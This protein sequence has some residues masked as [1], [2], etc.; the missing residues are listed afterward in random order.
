MDAEEQRRLRMELIEKVVTFAE[1]ILPSIQNN[2]QIV[3]WDAIK[4]QLKKKVGLK[5]SVSATITLSHHRK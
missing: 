2:P 5:E 3:E 1:E 4:Y